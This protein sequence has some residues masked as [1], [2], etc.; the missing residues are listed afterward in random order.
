MNYIK[1]AWDNVKHRKTRSF[2][3]VLSILIG[4]AA[5]FTLVSFGQ[6]LSN[7]VDVISSEVGADKLII[8]SKGIGAPGTDENFFI[9]REEV[10]FLGNINGISEIAGVYFSVVQI[11]HDRSK[12]FV[13]AGSENQE[14]KKL[15]EEAYTLKLHSGRKLKKGDKNKV[16]LAYNYLLPKKIYEKPLKIRDKVR[17]NDKEFE[18]VGFY[19]A[20]GNPQDDSNVYLTDEGF[21]N[22][23]PDTK[24]KFQFAIARVQEG[25]NPRDMA[26][27]AALK[28]RKF[29]DQKE[30]Q[31]DF[32]IMT[33]EQLIQTFN[34]IL[35]VINGVLVLIA[36]VSLVVAGV[37]I[38]NTMYTAVLE[39]TKEIGIL[40][41]IGAKNHNILF[42]F[43]IES[44][45]VGL[46][47]GVL[48]VS[49]GWGISELGGR[50]AADAGYQMLQPIFPLELIIGCL[51]FAFLVGALS[52]LMPARQASKLLPVDALRYE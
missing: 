34:N 8:Q 31:E 50:I 51:V 22:L 36:L 47:G 28:L 10:D 33:Y 21:E 27:K 17:V 40:K 46:F 45:L 4:I 23:L 42:I 44:G 41:A 48:G 3:T 15:I 25:I 38:M 14:F 24:D 13:F 7:F 11:E 19:E 2:L 18:V 12:K 43:L 16:V 5:I 37:N 35:G 32:F 6:G 26:E 30:G 9:T 49:L 39:R 20:V 29:K 1:Y 52:G